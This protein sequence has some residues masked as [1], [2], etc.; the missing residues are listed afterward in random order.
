[1]TTRTVRRLWT[2]LV[3]LS[4]FGLFFSVGYIRGGPFGVER[5]G[6]GPVGTRTADER[7]FVYIGSSGCGAANLPTMPDLIKASREKA[8]ESSQA[9]AR[10]FVSVGIATD[11]DV[12][13][14]LAHLAKF[15]AFDEVTTGRG[16]ANIGALKYVH[17]GLA[18]MPATPQVLVVDRHLINGDDGVRVTGERVLVRRVGVK[19]IEHW[20][21]T[22]ET[23]TPPADAGRIP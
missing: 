1:M 18:G 11:A 22:K 12:R 23:V 7:L 10:R 3:P 5:R 20:L 14:G 17:E 13:A 15:G 19:D 8:K 2:W 9:A 21:T 4:L 16:W 6:P